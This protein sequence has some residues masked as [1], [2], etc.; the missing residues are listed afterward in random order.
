MTVYKVSEDAKPTTVIGS[1]RFNYD[2]NAFNPL[3]FGLFF[4][5]DKLYGSSPD[6]PINL[7]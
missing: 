7:Y 4:R 2:V 3:D 6:S 1:Y 5:N